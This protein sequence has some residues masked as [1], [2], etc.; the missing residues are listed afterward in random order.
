[1]K[2]FGY[3]P[4][5]YI[6]CEISGLPA[7]DIHHIESRGSGG[8]PKNYKDRIENLMALTRQHHE[9]YGDKA[10]Y[11]SRLFKWHMN[12]LIDHGVKFDR[13]Y[14]ENKIKRYESIDAVSNDIA[15]ILD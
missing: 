5:D 8:D 4:G 12:R 3:D 13:N 14:I 6:P 1:M 11:M 2:A 7:V 10:I 15:T 9:H